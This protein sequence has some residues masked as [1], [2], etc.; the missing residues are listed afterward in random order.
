MRFTATKYRR[1]F[2]AA[3]ATA[4]F[5]S[6]LGLTPANAA[7]DY[8]DTFDTNFMKSILSGLGLR[9]SNEPGIAYHER[10]PLVVPPTRD[11]PPPQ[12]TGAAANPAWPKDPDVNRRRETK[13][14]ILNTGAAEQ[15]EMRQLRPG[16]LNSQRRSGNK[17]ASASSGSKA[18]TTGS[19]REEQL[20]PSQLG[21]GGFK[22]TN[23]KTWFDKEGTSIPFVKEP[24]RTSLTEPPPGLRTPSSRYEYGAKNRLEPTRE[25]KPDTAVGPAGER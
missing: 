23:P 3:A 25:N 7:D 15:E 6:M 18:E 5:G 10:S 8:E 4:L 20:P 24:E 22:W 2:A 9:E 19:T 17:S 13:R 16:E 1:M 11:L 14:V 21:F 12:S